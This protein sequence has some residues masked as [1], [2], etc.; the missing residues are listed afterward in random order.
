LRLHV[1]T[2]YK[3]STWSCII[4]LALYSQIIVCLFTCKAFMMSNCIKCL[5][6]HEFRY[7]IREGLRLFFQWFFEC[8][9]Y[10]MMCVK[11]WMNLPARVINF[12][13]KVNEQSVDIWLWIKLLLLLYYR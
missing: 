13:C 4:H 11:E 3:C 5:V 1:W 9:Q 6:K 10:E 8:I 2:V 7:D 12:S